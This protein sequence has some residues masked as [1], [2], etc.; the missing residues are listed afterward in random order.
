M[1]SEVLVGAVDTLAAIGIG[2]ALAGWL[3]ISPGLGERGLLGLIGVACAGAVAQ[4]F[5]P[6]S[7]VVQVV[8]AALGIL[9]AILHRRQIEDASNWPA[10]IG[11]A[12]GFVAVAWVWRSAPLAYD[13]GLYYLQTI[14]WL[15][16]FPLT[17]GLANLHGRLGF[18]SQD[19]VLLAALP[20]SGSPWVARSVLSGLIV[21][22]FV[23]RMDG[24]RDATPWRP[25]VFWYA[26]LA[27]LAF[28]TN[29]VHELSGPDF[30]CLALIAYWILLALQVTPGADGSTTD[31][32][33]LV[34]IGAFAA[35]VKLSA[36]PVLGLT[37]AGAVW[38]WNSG[39]IQKRVL[40]LCALLFGVWLLRGLLLS[41]CAL[42][43][44]RQ[45]CMFVLP[46][47]VRPEQVTWHSMAIQSWARRPEVFDYHAVLGNWDWL[48]P[49]F[50]TA[51]DE[52]ILRFAAAG[53]MAYLLSCMGFMGRGWGRRRAYG[54][55]GFLAGCIAW[56]FFS[57]P[58][59]RFG[60]GFLI[61]FGLLGF[62]LLA[63]LALPAPGM[64]R[65]GLVILPAVVVV[66]GIYAVVTA[67]PGQTPVPWAVETYELRTPSE[68]RVWIPQKGQLCWDHELPCTPYIHVDSWRRI[69]WPRGLPTFAESSFSAPA[70]WMGYEAEDSRRRPAMGV[71]AKR[72]GAGQ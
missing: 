68:P 10:L 25:E 70:D 28:V 36:L 5:F 17:I 22:S 38:A 33:L 23:Q 53:A 39:W 19:F 44:V 1:L 40:G 18:N 41:G 37:L 63:S 49:W 9:L 2:S 56:W 57:A 31:Y 54:L 51:L 48:R 62:S 26:A 20:G 64:L 15:R 45:S 13:E 67:A 12:A 71:P 72:K 8:F 32:A 14:K 46:W 59:V 29:P 65:H 21:A 43:P 58:D 35:T 42:Y 50:S 7:G 66:A 55:G 47:S 27:P 16:Q 24:L 69:W 61:C 11:L 6:L 34:T 3:R 60:A 4:L 52:P 30:L